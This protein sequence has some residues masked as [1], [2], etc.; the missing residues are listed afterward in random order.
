[1]MNQS[2]SLID[3]QLRLNDS[4]AFF[5]KSNEERLSFVIPYMIAGFRNNERCVYIA[6]ENTVPE[7]LAEFKKADIDIDAATASGALSVVTKHD[8]YL[9]NGIFDPARMIADL[10][11]SVRFALQQGFFGLRITGEMSW[12]LDLPSALTRLCEYEQ[13]LY[14]H[15]PSQLTG[16]CQ[17]NET[18]FPRDVIEKIANCH[19]AVVR[20]GKIVRNPRHMPAEKL[21]A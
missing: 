18:L 5:F 4:V 1:M 17:Y 2:A 21:S 8:T 10:D 13:E 7:I 19:A 14:R 3:E 9:R 12:A 15:W 20:D 16:L 11:G 6:V